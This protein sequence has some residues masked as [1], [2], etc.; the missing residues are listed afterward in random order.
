MNTPTG[1]EQSRSDAVVEVDPAE[2]LTRQRAG[3]LLIDVREDTEHAAGMPLDA[4]GL[5]RGM[6]EQR[7]ADVAPNR[8]R[9][10]LTLC[11]S[12]RR[13]L[14]AAATLCD[15]GYARVASVRG[16][17]AAWK[18]IGL[19][20]AESTIDADTADRYARHLM[21]PEIGTVGQGRLAAARI[22]LIGAGGLGA[23]AALY[24]AAAGVGR[25]TVIDD[26]R[27]E[28]SN[29]QRQIIHVDA[30]IGMAK[31]E[32]AQLALNALNPRIRIDSKSERLRAANV[33]ALIRD[34]D[35]VIDG[36]D[37]FPT[38]YLLNAA[39]LKLGMPLIYGAV[40]RFS[41]QVSVFDTRR[42]DSPCYRCL[43]PEPPAGADAPNCSE[44]GV[45]GVVPGI[46]GLLQ[47]TEAMKLVLRV[48]ASLVGRLLCYDALAARFSE[49]ALPRDPQCPG[50]GSAATFE[51]YTDI[52]EICARSDR[53]R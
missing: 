47:A 7:I 16:G 3:A 25:L 13:S 21:L 44:A 5:A 24:L 34:H 52:A 4:V 37:N 49:L 45:L 30:R 39:C 35:V 46:V 6:L 10:I 9:E 31:T 8:E 43:F 14:L 12:G 42:N 40:H 1:R 23:P 51:S 2:A 50:C 27:V 15:L 22:A 41:G 19:P 48:G 38:R 53:E 18:Q 32:S 33:E 26:D 36:A 17:F 11:A 28:R 20:L 29:L